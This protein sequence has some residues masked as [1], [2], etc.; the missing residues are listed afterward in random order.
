MSTRRTTIATLLLAMAGPPA[1]VAVSRRLFGASPPLATQFVLHLVFCAITLAIVLVVTRVERL[2]LASIGLHRPGWATVVSGL[3][4]GLGA[5]WLLP[6]LT[7]PLVRA[8]PGARVQTEIHTLVVWPVWFRV[9]VGAT[10]GFVEETIYRGYAVERLATLTGSRWIGGLLAA[11]AFA[12]AHAPVWSIGY[13]LA[14]D[15]PFG[16]VMTLFYLW[17]RDLLANGL[18]HSTGLVITLA[19][20]TL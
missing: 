6:L 13:A 12:L 15:L 18:A 11:L 2:P 5:L 19:N 3:L 7:Q 16:I 10:S 9:F 17:R 1:L 14:A 20:L 8:V 4:L